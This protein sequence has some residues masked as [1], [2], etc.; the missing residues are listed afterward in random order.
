MAVLIAV[1]G[2]SIAATLMIVDVFIGSGR[3]D[4][5]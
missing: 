5:E 1:I 2:F 4:D 3:R